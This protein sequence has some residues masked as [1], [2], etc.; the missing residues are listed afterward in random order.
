MPKIPRGVDPSP[1]VKFLAKRGWTRHEGGRHILM[2]RGGVII[3]V[4]RHG[5]IGVAIVAKIIRASGESL[6]VWVR[7]L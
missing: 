3:P 5:P 6:E 7:E 1:V 2:K 4:P